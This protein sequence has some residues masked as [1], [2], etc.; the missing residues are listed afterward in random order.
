MCGIIGYAGMA[1]APEILLESIRKL[2]YRGYDSAGI[3]V[4]EKCSLTTVKALG[5]IKNLE[6]SLAQRLASRRMA[7]DHP[8]DRDPARSAIRREQAHGG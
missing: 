1:N 8:G 6:Q 4:K 5:E 7:L 2:E 3:T